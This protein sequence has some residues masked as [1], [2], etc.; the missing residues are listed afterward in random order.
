MAANLNANSIFGFNANAQGSANA[1]RGWHKVTLRAIAIEIR[2]IYLCLGNWCAL[3]S[4]RTPAAAT[5]P[6]TCRSIDSTRRH[7]RHQRWMSGVVVD[8]GTVGVC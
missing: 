7:Q 6:A 1:V 4:K 3:G 2:G 5:A 8:P